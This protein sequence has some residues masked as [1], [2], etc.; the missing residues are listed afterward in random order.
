M[1]QDQD[2]VSALPGQDSPEGRK[3]ASSGIHPAV[4]AARRY[5]RAVPGGERDAVIATGYTPQSRWGGYHTARKCTDT[6]SALL[7][8]WYRPG[9]DA[10]AV[11]QFRPAE[12]VMGT[13]GH[14]AK[15]LQ[16]KGA[17][18]VIDVHPSVPR[19]WLD[20]STVPLLVTEGLL[21]ADA[22]VS[23]MVGDLP[24]D[25]SPEEVTEAL[26]VVPEMARV[27]PVAIYGVTTWKGSGEWTHLPP[28]DRDVYVV[29]DADV[30][31]NADVARQAR[32]VKEVIENYHGRFH[33]VDLSQL[34][35][36]GT[37]GVDDYLA[38][39]EPG[40]DRLRA[41]DDMLSAVLARVPDVSGTERVPGKAYVEGEHGEKV[42]LYKPT[43]SPDEPV[44]RVK[45][46]GVGGYVSAIEI[47]R[48]PT[49]AE[50][51][52][53]RVRDDVSSADDTERLVR[54]NVT[55]EDPDTGIGEG[56]IL[57]PEKILS[58]PP[59]RWD[60]VPGVQ[61]PTEV[62]LLPEWPP[63]R[64]W[65][66]AVKRN[67][68][69]QYGRPMTSVRSTVN[70][71]VPGPD[72]VPVFTFGH[73]Q[74]GDN[75]T[76]VLSEE[77]LRFPGVDKFGLPEIKGDW[78]QVA[79]EVIPRVVS[80][81]LSGAWTNPG[82]ALMTLAAGMR[83]AIPVRPKTTLYFVGSR[84][85]GKTWS[86]SCVIGF[87][88]RVAGAFNSRS[89][90]GS[91][92][93]TYAFVESIISKLPVW[94]ADDL[95]PSVSAGAAATREGGISDLIRAVA[96]GSGRNRMGANMVARAPVSPRA[97]F[98]VTAE[99]SLTI[100]SAR[101]RVIPVNIASGS[102]G[103]S[104][105]VDGV[106]KMFAE[107]VDASTLSACLI[108]YLIEGASKNSWKDV[109]DLCRW[110]E[111]EIDRLTT[112]L[113]EE[114]G[115]DRGAA[116]RFREM[117]SDVLSPIVLLRHLCGPKVL[118]ISGDE[119]LAGLYNGDYMRAALEIVIDAVRERAEHSP[120]AQMMLAIK[121]TLASGRGHVTDDQGEQ[122]VR[123]SGGK[124]I[125]MLLGWKSDPERGMQPMGDRIGII[126]ECSDGSREVIF[127]AQATFKVASRNFPDLLPSGTKSSESYAAMKAE[128]ML[129]QSSQKKPIIAR[130]IGGR[131]HN[132][133][134]IPLENLLP[135]EVIEEG[136]D[137]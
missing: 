105:K 32:R 16:A 19:Q 132:G 67:T 2:N 120:G 83:P 94:L 109:I 40:Q 71:W 56:V 11:I 107:T 129:A 64:D 18:T 8:P 122:P 9:T 61:V 99:N 31:D 108:H 77:R 46:V 106:S 13:D 73:S 21:K 54:I 23:A 124:R 7:M 111:E 116:T 98:I 137:E 119:R 126:R 27:V 96:N 39:R 52:S 125:N 33:L 115:I 92:N 89:T 86:A 6:G 29:F 55:Y 37:D 41:I 51:R 113:L 136:D 114:A 26:R 85:T 110:C 4:A 49:E 102:L 53:G 17:P 47:K 63:G 59:D 28:R 68:A 112:I 22:V 82:V 42:V 78:R 135:P 81:M 134:C 57:G 93:D 128:G 65:L 133:V 72:G 38:G 121:E 43:G 87:W 88:A 14:R 101:D 30:R 76:V 5:T 79:K 91:A 25:A 69:E 15:Y 104:E 48:A 123:G 20:D 100:S 127:Y 80:T 70:G 10:P 24:E 62:S 45:L 34:G 58:I 130:R 90:G 117:S 12:P 3:L 36:T 118:N 97:L 131:V 84:G 75:P 35:V 60:R 95:A 50:V 103:S 44:R 66:D 1:S 74:I